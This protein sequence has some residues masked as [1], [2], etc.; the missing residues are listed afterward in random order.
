[1]ISCTKH[2]TI[3]L[4]LLSVLLAAC[5]DN[6]PIPAR[7]YHQ[8]KH[9]NVTTLSMTS[10]IFS[11]EIF[12][13]GK[14][15]ILDHGFTWGKTRPF[16]DQSGFGVRNLGSRTGKGKFTISVDYTFD[17]KTT[18]YVRPFVRTETT[19]VYGDIISFRPNP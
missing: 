5:S 17:K 9:D 6:S 8:L 11:A 14:E 19:M 2:F 4:L 3:L 10:V 15:P 12:T 1:M 18:Y 16:V 7:D 13:Q